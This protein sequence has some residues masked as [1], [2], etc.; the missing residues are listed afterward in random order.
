MAALGTLYSRRGIITRERFHSGKQINGDCAPF[1][2]RPAW[3]PFYS[4]E[5]LLEQRDHALRE[6]R[7]GTPSAWL[8]GLNRLDEGENVRREGSGVLGGAD[9]ALDG[10]AELGPALQEAKQDLSAVAVAH[11]PDRCRDQASG[12]QMKRDQS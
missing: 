9:D 3:P 6:Q 7:L 2:A 8:A 10:R 1:R 5:V 11:A 4:I 12:W